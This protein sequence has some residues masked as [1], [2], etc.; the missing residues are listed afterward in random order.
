MTIRVG[1]HGA[2]KGQGSDKLGLRHGYMKGVDEMSG[3]GQWAGDVSSDRHQDV[4]MERA[5]SV[6]A[7]VW[8]SSF[9][10]FHSQCSA[11]KPG[12]SQDDIGFCFLGQCAR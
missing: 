1:L 2:K 12:S 6:I 8:F 11:V 5:S 7:F 3:D 10:I 9:Q 4:L